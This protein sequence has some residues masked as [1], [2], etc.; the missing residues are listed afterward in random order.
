MINV[1]DSFVGVFGAMF[2]EEFGEVT[3]INSDGTVTV[4]FDDGAV[5]TYE[6]DEIRTD[7]MSPVGSPIGIYVYNI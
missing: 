2:P 1:G 3:K 4:F 5:K 6:Q 7:Y